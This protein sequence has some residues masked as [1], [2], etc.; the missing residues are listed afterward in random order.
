MNVMLSYSD[1]RSVLNLQES[2]SIAGMLNLLPFLVKSIGECE[3][4]LV[5]LNER[6][7][8]Y[9]KDLSIC[10]PRTGQ[11]MVVRAGLGAG[12]LRNPSQSAHVM[13]LLTHVMR[14]ARLPRVSRVVSRFAWSCFLAAA[15]SLPSCL[16]LIVLF[17]LLVSN[18]RLI[19]SLKSS[20][21]SNIRFRKRNKT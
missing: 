4:Q 8:L 10:I 19:P 13:G 14:R 2:S 18:N 7:G 5:L 16:R 9:F 17:V 3:P 11:Y 21:R 15:P 12:C 20:F 6:A 1:R